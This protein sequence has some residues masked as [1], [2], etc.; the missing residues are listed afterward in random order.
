MFPFLVVVE[1]SLTNVEA[2]KPGRVASGNTGALAPDESKKLFQSNVPVWNAVLP[3]VV[4]LPSSSNCRSCT[5]A[6]PLMNTSPMPSAAMRHV[7]RKR[8]KDAV[9]AA[10]QTVLVVDDDQR[11]RDFARVTIERA[12]FRADEAADADQALEAASL[13][14]PHLVLLDVRLPHVSG[15]ELYRE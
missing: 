13:H 12:G 3:S 1:K 7:V 10:R 2:V 14:E 15:Y 6:A 5:A 8:G 9:P 4:V 11:F